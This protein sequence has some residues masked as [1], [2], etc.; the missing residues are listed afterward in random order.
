MAHVVDEY[1]L[2]VWHRPKERYIQIGASLAFSY[3][4]CKKF[5]E[6][7]KVSVG[8]AKYADYDFTD[9]HIKMRRITYTDWEVIHD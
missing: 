1:I 5:A 6:E 8:M 3:D 7:Y 9:Y 2:Y 4:D